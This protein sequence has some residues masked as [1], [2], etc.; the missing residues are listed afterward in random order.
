MSKVLRNFCVH[1]FQCFQY[2]RMEGVVVVF[3][4]V[5]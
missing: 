2:L 4:I 1:F 5:Q 3:A